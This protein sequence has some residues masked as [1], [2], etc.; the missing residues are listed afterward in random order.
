VWQKFCEVDICA[1]EG[2]KVGSGAFV[3][4]AIIDKIYGI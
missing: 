4:I 3:G 1:S 2:E